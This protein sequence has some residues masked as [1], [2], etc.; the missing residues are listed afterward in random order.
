MHAEDQSPGTRLC[1]VVYYLPPRNEPD[2]EIGNVEAHHAEQLL[3]V[4]LSSIPFRYASFTTW[5]ACLALICYVWPVSV[6]LT[7]KYDVPYN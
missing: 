6:F 3:L 5:H 7:K 1:L 2:N 4:L